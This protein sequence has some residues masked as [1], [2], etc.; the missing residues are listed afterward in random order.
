MTAEEQIVEMA[1]DDFGN[2]LK[3][4]TDETDDVQKRNAF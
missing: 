2:E 1:D 4:I 3:T